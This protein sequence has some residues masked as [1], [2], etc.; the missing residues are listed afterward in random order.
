M[1]AW[2]NSEQRYGAVAIALHWGMVLLLAIVVAMG[3]YMVRL[4]DA[5]Y[6]TEKITLILVHKSLGMLALVLVVLR[7]A[8]RLGNALPKLVA[9]LPMWQQVSARFVHLMFYALMFAVPVTG[10]LMSSAGGYPVPFFGWFDVPDLIGHDDWLFQVLDD[11]H[12]WL[13]WM[14]VFFFVLHA[15]AALRHHYGLHDDTLERMLP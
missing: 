14:L 12:R 1:A 3:L 4:P 11:V 5:G 2:A 8:W 13:A 9:T 7:L 6:D 10:W 15:A